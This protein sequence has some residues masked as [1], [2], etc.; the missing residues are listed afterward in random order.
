MLGNSLVAL[1]TQA[2]LDCSLRGA[3][4]LGHTDKLSFFEVLR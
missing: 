1:A 4:G 2:G 3:R